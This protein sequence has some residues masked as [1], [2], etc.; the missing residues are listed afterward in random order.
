M[1]R[2]TSVAVL[3]HSGLDELERHGYLSLGCHSVDLFGGSQFRLHDV[4]EKLDPFLAG[5]FVSS[6]MRAVSSA[7]GAC[8]S[9]LLL[10]ISDHVKG[11]V[12]IV[13]VDV[14][15]HCLGSLCL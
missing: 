1:F 3:F 2:S 8:S 14:S 9:E 13:V 5:S 7:M 12:L 11:G 15:V 4:L 10:T 6:M